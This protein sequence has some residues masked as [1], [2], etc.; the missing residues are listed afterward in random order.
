MFILVILLNLLSFSSLASIKYN[1][2]TNDKWLCSIK[3]I[4][5]RLEFKVLPPGKRREQTVHTQNE[6][7][8]CF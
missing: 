1:G 3:I 5:H 6:S 2:T 7:V 4:V 8:K